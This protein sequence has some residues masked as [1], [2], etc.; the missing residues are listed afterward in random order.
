MLAGAEEDGAMLK[1]K[2]TINKGKIKVHL[3]TNFFFPVERWQ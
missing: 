1:I 3:D 2:A